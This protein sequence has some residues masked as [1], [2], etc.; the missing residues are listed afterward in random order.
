VKVARFTAAAVA[1]ACSACSPS[2]GLYPVAGKV[3]YNGVPARGAT[4]LLQRRGANPAREQTMM[5]ITEEDGS[6][7]IDCGAL[8]KGAPA[9]EY[10]VLIKWKYDPA[11]PVARSP[12]EAAGRPDRLGGRY[13]D[14]ERPLLHAVVRP[15]RNVIPTFELSQ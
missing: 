10:A 14:P 9:G 5:G 8:G 3:L 15:E 11:M 13:A 4:V 1:L 12:T 7:T 2:N 6:F